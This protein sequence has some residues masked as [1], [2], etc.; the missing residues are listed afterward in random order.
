MSSLF[1]TPEGKTALLGW[2]DRF[3]ARVPADTTTREVET[4]YGK[5]HVL[6][7]GREDAPPLVL[8]HGAMASSA[9]A[10]VELAPLLSAF[11]VYAVDVIGQS[12]KSA[13]TRLRVDDDSYGRWLEEVME[14]LGLA[15]ARVVGISWG[16][17]VTIRLAAYAPRRIERLSLL[18]PAGVVTGPKW[19]GFV[20]LG[21]PMARYI[22]SPSPQRL[23]ALVEHLLTTRDDDWVPFLGEAFKT[24]DLKGMRIPALAKPEEL[25]AFDAPVQVLGAAQDISFP[26]GALLERAGKLF[27]RVEHSE[28]IEGAKHCPPTNDAFRAWLGE[29]M[30]RFLA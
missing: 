29:R 22:M 12:V 8:L 3:R 11:R 30:L 10:L 17:F 9:H 5:T 2:Y 23:E 7:G 1:K 24:Y 28:L 20:K 16:G 14:Q 6:V 27:K 25:A 21:W 26:G 19:A 18:V 4:R 15:R 13:D